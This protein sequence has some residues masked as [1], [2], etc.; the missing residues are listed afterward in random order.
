M[1]PLQEARGFQKFRTLQACSSSGFFHAPRPEVQL[2]CWL[3]Q[4]NGF[5]AGIPGFHWGGDFLRVPIQ[6]PSFLWVPLWNQ[7]G[8]SHDV[9]FHWREGQGKLWHRRFLGAMTW[10]EPWRQDLPMPAVERCGGAGVFA[11]LAE[12]CFRR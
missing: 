4:G 11:R 2:G 3:K 8:T 9:S 10:P 1:R 5:T 7:Q 12:I 6:T